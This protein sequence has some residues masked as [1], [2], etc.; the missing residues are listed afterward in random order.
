MSH[1]T[2]GQFEDILQGRAGVP[3]H[4]DQCSRCRARLDEKRVL[5]DRVRTAFSSIHAGP[6]LA[7]RIQAQIAAAPPA[8]AKARPRI[9][10]LH[11]R[12]QI[13]SA[14][15]IAA[16]VLVVV[17]LRS[18][19]V[20]TSSRVRAAQTAL[21]GLHLTNLDS[22]EERM[23]D[24]GPRKPCNCE[25]MKSKSGNGTT[26][27]CCE[28]GLCVCGCQEREFQGRLVKCCAIQHPNAPAIS[29]VVVPESP[30]ALGMTPVATT[31][32]TGQTIWQASCGSCN[33]A[34]VRLGEG[35]CCVIGQ[36]PPEDLVAVLNAFEE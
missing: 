12:R 35:S 29:V 23:A 33:M 13:W 6:D 25:C 7:E 8:A 24:E 34:S 32:V 28:R 18:S 27:P 3:E 21:I 1:L 36:V 2:E 30:E 10:P 11:A 17:I 14:L 4:V 20:D 16:T 22:L 15:A 9:I 5:A 26:M 19:H 31:T